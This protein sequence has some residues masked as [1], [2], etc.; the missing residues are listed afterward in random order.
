MKKK[1]GACPP[2]FAALPSAGG[3]RERLFQGAKA[4]RLNACPHGLDTG[5]GPAQKTRPLSQGGAFFVPGHYAL[6][7][8]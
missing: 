8:F 1:G 7:I 6:N 4:S 2:F 3:P 5:G